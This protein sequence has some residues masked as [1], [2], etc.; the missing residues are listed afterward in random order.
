MTSVYSGSYLTIPATGSK[1]GEG[2]CF[3]ARSP[4]QRL[5]R[6]SYVHQDEHPVYAQYNSFDFLDSHS[7]LTWSRYVLKQPLLRRA[8]CFQERLLSPRLLH[9][10]GQKMVWECRTATSCECDFLSHTARFQSA[11]TEQYRFN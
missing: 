9:F 1:N 3:F 10:H 6:E 4:G 11:R 7:D 2:G 8:W 5:S